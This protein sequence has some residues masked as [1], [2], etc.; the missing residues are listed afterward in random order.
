M[1]IGDRGLGHQPLRGLPDLREPSNVLYPIGLPSLSAVGRVS[2]FPVA[3]RGGDVGPEEAR[4][5]FLS[6][7]H[8]ITI[9]RAHT[10]LEAPFHGRVQRT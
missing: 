8:V 10:V 5:N 1:I 6:V 4:E 2:L 3:G 7:E 9:E